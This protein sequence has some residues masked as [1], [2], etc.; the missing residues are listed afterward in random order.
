VYVDINGLTMFYEIRGASDPAGVRLV[1]LHGASSAMGTSF[2]SLLG[3]WPRLGE[4]VQQLGEPGVGP[5][6]N[7]YGSGVTVLCKGC[8]GD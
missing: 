8:G 3:C 1:L 5:C 4:Q 2:G 7:R 6:R